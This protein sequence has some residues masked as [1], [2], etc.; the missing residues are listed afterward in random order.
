VGS[1][2]CHC[3]GNRRYVQ[4]V[5]NEPVMTPDPQPVGQHGRYALMSLR[6]D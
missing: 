6:H 1:N 2:N 5:I 3:R 4:G